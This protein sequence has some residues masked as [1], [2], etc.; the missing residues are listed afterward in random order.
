MEKKEQKEI[1]EARISSKFGTFLNSF[2][3]DVLL[4]TVAFDYNNYSYSSDIHGVWTIKI[5]IFSSKYTFT[6]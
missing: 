5:K 3:V 2:L 1:E 4:F 6:A